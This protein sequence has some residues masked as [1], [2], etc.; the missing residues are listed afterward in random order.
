M[1]DL[2]VT[3]PPTSC[4]DRG[5]TPVERGAPQCTATSKRTKLRCQAPAVSGRTVCYHHG[6]ASLVGAANPQFKH[7]RHSKYLPQPLA[8]RHE[9]RLA[10]IEIV[11]RLDEEISLLDARISELCEQLTTGERGTVWDDLLAL[12]DDAQTPDEHGRT[13]DAAAIITA[14]RPIADKGK[15]NVQAWRDLDAAI[16]SKAKITATEAKRAADA[17]EIATRDEVRTL[18]LQI[19]NVVKDHVSDAAQLRSIS[20]DLAIVLQGPRARLQP[21]TTPSETA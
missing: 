11:K 17:G 4:P 6:G 18:V 12:I 2:P 8:E 3:S 10:R 20:N 5:T 7:G 9:E 13:M 21:A 1:N 16:H 14:L 19:V 15:S